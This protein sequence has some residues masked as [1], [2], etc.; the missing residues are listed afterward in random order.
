MNTAFNLFRSSVAR[1]AL[2]MLTIAVGFF[3]MPFLVSKLGDQW[4]GIWTIIGSLT[5]YFYLV[6]FGLATAVT[7]YVTQYITRND[8]EAANIVINTSL[9]VYSG[10]ALGI[11]LLTLVIIIFADSFIQNPQALSIIRLT[12]L[13][14]GFNMAIEFPYKAFAGIIG[15]YVRYDLLTYSHFLMLLVSTVATVIFLSKG[16]G[17]LTLALIGFLS[18]QLSNILFFLISKHLYSG[19]VIRWKYFRTSQVRTL[20]GYS[21]WSFLVQISDQV[22]FKV[23]SLVI[24]WALS[25]SHVTH[26]FIG[27]RLAEYFITLIFKATN[28]LMPVFTQYYADNNYEEIRSK[29]LFLTKVNTVLA[30]F[31]GG[32]IIMVGLPFISRWMGNRYLDAYPVLVALIIAFMAEGIYNPSSNVMYAIAK[33]HY[34]AAVNSAE[35]VLNLVLSIVFVHYWGI[36]GVAIGTAIPLLISRLFVLPLYTCRFI[37]LPLRKY[38]SNILITIFFTISY[39]VLFY[40]GIKNMLSVPQYGTIIG[41]CLSALPIYLLAILFVAFDKSD[42]ALLRTMIPYKLW[43]GVGR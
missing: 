26:Y 19:M 11:T 27:A 29:L 32:L 37:D 24:V 14:M 10:M 30:V 3:M 7:R 12:I 34:L 38:Y 18:S 28:I 43:F 16:Y 2:M 36:L 1:T 21:V 25:A 22:R 15:A 35:A 20:F 41:V 6:D 33:H 42:R 40:M 31:G 9:V 8:H 4:Y 13:V 23:D 39:Q 17:I 5:G